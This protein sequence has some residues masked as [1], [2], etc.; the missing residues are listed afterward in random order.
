MA[1]SP[2]LVH[3]SLDLWHPDCWTTKIT[4]RVDAGL[5][6]HGVY[7]EREGT[8]K[9]RFT[10]YSETG[11][12]VDRLVEQARA[13]DLTNSVI[14]A[15]ER[16]SQTRRQ[17]SRAGN[18]I[19]ELFVEFDALNSIDDAFVTRGFVYDGPTRITDGREKWRLVTHHTREE[20]QTRL[21][22]IRT[23]MDAEI[24]VTRIST[25]DNIH[26]RRKPSTDQLSARQREVF[27]LARTEGYYEWPRE[28]SACEL[29]ETMGITKTTFLEHLRKAES[30][31]LTSVP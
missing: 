8:A 26:A 1:V 2:E 16:P 15:R 7:T 21:E 12:K 17:S 28:I 6:G 3:L 11:A 24:T 14:E 20:I 19:R 29:A 13:S 5:L 25:T 31:L 27:E 18:T 9:G 4:D 10:A 23:R 22:E 30:K